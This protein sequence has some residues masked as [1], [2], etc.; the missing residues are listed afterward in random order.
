MTNNNTHKLL[1]QIIHNKHMDHKVCGET[2]ILESSVNIGIQAHISF[3]L[4]K[5]RNIS[6]SILNLFGSH[7]CINKRCSALKLTVP[8]FSK[9]FPVG[10]LLFRYSAV[11]N[12]E[13][14]ACRSHRLST[15]LTP[16]TKHSSTGIHQPHL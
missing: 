16:I 4:N 9:I 7:N 6:L 10:S 13:R 11:L 12:Y 14:Q 5:V 8:L 3:L 2:F 1:S 15:T